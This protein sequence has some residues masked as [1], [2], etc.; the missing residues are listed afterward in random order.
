MP[1]LIDPLEST[2]SNAAKKVIE[3]L[4]K[5]VLKDRKEVF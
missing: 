2:T 1:E 5:S 4:M 3:M